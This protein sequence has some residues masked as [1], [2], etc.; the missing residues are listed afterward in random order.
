MARRSG[1]ERARTVRTARLTPESRRMWE[2]YHADGLARDVY[3][4][5]LAER[6][7]ADTFQC[8][9]WLYDRFTLPAEVGMAGQSG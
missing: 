4:Q 5:M 7:E 9:A 2:L 3:F 1:F 6:S 8:L